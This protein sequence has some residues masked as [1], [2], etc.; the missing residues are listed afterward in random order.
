MRSTERGTVLLEVM[1]ALTILLASG[2]SL[3]SLLGASLASEASLAQR[4]AELR[5]LDRLL[6]AM[7]LLTREDLDRRLGRHPVGSLTAEVQRPES[8]LYRLAVS[9]TGEGPLVTVVYRPEG[10]RP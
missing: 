7:T 6:T 1:I 9:R 4:E 8:G 3:L 10:G 2:V 5:D